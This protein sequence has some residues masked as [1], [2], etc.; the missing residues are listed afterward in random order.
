[1][2]GSRRTEEAQ[3]VDR[4]LAVAQD[5]VGEAISLGGHRDLAVRAGGLGEGSVREVGRYSPSHGG[6]EQLMRLSGDQ[7]EVRNRSR[8]RKV[9][10]Q[11]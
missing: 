5:S 2:S 3:I 1:M 7:S 4:E 10:L 8:E 9:D 11:R 6:D